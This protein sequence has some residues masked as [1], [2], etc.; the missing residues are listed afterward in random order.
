MRGRIPRTLA[1]S[2]AVRVKKMIGVYMGRDEIIFDNFRIL[3]FMQFVD[4]LWKGEL[5]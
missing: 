2:K 3:P 5:L 4:E 1:A